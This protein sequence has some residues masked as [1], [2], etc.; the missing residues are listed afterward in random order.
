MTVE[1]ILFK[2]A[3]HLRLKYSTKAKGRAER[4]RIRTVESSVFN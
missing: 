3:G 4:R 1:R 2:A